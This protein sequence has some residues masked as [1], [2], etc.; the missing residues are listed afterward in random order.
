M[1]SVDSHLWPLALVAIAMAIMVAAV[2]FASATPGFAGFNDAAGSIPPLPLA[3][4]QVS[5]FSC[6]SVSEIPMAECEAL[7]ALFN[8]T[9][10]RQPSS[11]IPPVKRTG[12]TRS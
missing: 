8:A 9:D 3:R 2:A 4:V 1:S 10:D 5:P 7:S 6:S 11:G 12:C